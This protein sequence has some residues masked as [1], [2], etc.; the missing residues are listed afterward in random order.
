MPG[1]I[2]KA[3][4]FHA[5]VFLLLCFQTVAHA[6]LAQEHALEHQ[7]KATF[8]YKFGSY[9]EWPQGT[10]MHEDEPLIIGVIG[11]D[12]VAAD[13]K[14]I[15]RDKQ[16]NGRPV[17]VVVLDPSAPP[18]QAQILFIG[19]SAPASLASVLSSTSGQPI[20][21]VTEVEER[22]GEGGII[23]FVTDDNKVRFDVLLAKADSKNIKISA[24][25]LR[26]ARKVI[27]EGGP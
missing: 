8:L 21:T 11:A 22:S 14:E 18:R 25:L 6:V 27:T 2:W 7:I 24:R 3:V 1:S 4:R 20:V 5:A 13:L 16:I 26:V 12:D 17:S 23:N 19:R 10:F 9:I 15:V